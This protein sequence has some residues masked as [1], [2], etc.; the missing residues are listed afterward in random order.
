MEDVHRIRE[1][2]TFIRKKAGLFVHRKFLLPLHNGITKL[3]KDRSQFRIYNT[4]T[5][6]SYCSFMASN[7][8][9]CP[10]LQFR[11]TKDC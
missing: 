3:T 8:P 2:L 6:S 10:S 1:T 9:L 11:V 5:G 4:R 7:H